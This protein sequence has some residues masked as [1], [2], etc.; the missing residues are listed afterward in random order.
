MYARKFAKGYHRLHKEYM[1][2][3]CDNITALGMSDNANCWM[4]VK[5]ANIV[6]PMPEFEVAFVQAC[7]H[8]SMRMKLDYDHSND[9]LALFE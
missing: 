6:T 8:S 4:A 1:R 2:Y 5:N 7:D 3:S 9:D